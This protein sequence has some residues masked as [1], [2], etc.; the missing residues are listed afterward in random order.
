MKC[1]KCGGGYLLAIYRYCG[2]LAGLAHKGL[3][4][5]DDCGC[6]IWRRS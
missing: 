1:P 4:E 2:V 5:C 6:R 3:Y